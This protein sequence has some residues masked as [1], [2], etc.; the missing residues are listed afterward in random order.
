MKFALNVSWIW[1]LSMEIA[2]AKKEWN[3][4]KENVKNVICTK[5]IVYLIAL[6]IPS[7]RIIC[8]WFY[9]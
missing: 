9:K 8:V 3:S 4:K 2:D 5:V 7:S 6:N 1:Y